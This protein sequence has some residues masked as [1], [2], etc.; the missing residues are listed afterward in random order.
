MRLSF[1]VLSSS[2]PKSTPITRITIF[3]TARGGHDSS[4]TSHISASNIDLLHSTT[5]VANGTES[6]LISLW[7]IFAA[8]VAVET[9]GVS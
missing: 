6:G 7:A 2:D 1:I 4:T 8:S 3:S 9:E 5:Q